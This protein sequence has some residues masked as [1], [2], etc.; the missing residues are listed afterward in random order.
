MLS[1]LQRR[2]RI[3]GA[4]ACGIALI[5][6][7]LFAW[8]WSK[9]RSS[10]PALDGSMAIAGLTAPVTIERDSLGVPTLRG[11]S[12]IDLA[13]ALGFVHGQD[14]FFQ[15]DL[16]R[17]RAAGELAE[18][19]G[20]IALPLDR[21]ARVH[22]LRPLSLKMLSQLAPEEHQL[23][24]AYAAGVNAALKTFADRPWEYLVLRTQPKPWATS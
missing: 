7:L 15:M 14:R 13:R 6:L 21:G 11:A 22:E 2:L 12:R 18:L 17:R 24:E 4:A 20:S 9:F 1:T 16:S 3:I 10:L 8:A 23:I 19:F 5:A